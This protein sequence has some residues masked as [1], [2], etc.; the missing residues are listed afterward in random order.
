MRNMFFYKPKMLSSFVIILVLNIISSAFASNIPNAQELIEQF[1]IKQQELVYLDHGKIIFFDL[2]ESTESELT[3]GAA[4][5]MP[6]EPSKVAD[7]IKRED[8]ESLDEA[9]N[10]AGVIPLNAT[11]DTFKDFGFRAESVEAEDFLSATPGFRF[12]LSKQ[13]FQTLRTINTTQANVASEVYR[14]FLWQ[15]WQ[16][17]RK[18]G[19]QGISPYD[20]GNGEQTNPSRQLQMASLESKFLAYYFPKIFNVWQNY[21]VNLPVGVQ[22]AFFWNNREVQGYSTAILVHRITFS[23]SAGELILARQ[24][25]VGRSFNANQ[26]I[27]ICLPYHKGSLVFYL[28]RTFTDQIT[29]FGSSL[30]QLI[31]N[32][33]AQT[34]VTKLLKNLRS[35]IR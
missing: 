24:F 29:G 2:K 8:L 5:Y 31:G 12:N 7:L 9:V 6:S 35:S 18:N 28:N 16:S 30:K 25:Y 21:P 34:E 11:L 1:G 14:E 26:L 10:A 33:Q 23:E 3:T 22:E 19:L 20:R 32:N 17:Y 15:R 27:I 4:M 13:E